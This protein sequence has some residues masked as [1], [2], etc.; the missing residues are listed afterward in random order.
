M[1]ILIAVIP[2][3]IIRRDNLTKQALKQHNIQNQAIR[4]LLQ[5]RHLIPPL[6]R[7]PHLLRIQPGIHHYPYNPAGVLQS[8]TP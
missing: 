5:H 1:I 2:D 8:R 6:L 4:R 7:I 3:E